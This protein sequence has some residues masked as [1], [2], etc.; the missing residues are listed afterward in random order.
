M[1]RFEQAFAKGLLAGIEKV[2]GD[3]PLPRPDQASASRQAAQAAGGGSGTKPAEGTK[4]AIKRLL[5]SA[6]N[7][8]SDVV[9]SAKAAPKSVK[10][11]L[12]AMWGEKGAKGTTMRRALMIGAPTAAAGLGIAGGAGLA[13]LL[14]KKS[15]QAE[16]A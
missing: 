9:E 7:K 13:S 8:A 11:A 4:A 15:K 12:K 2:A 3:M 1:D 14:R 6:K 10:E 16:G 5:W